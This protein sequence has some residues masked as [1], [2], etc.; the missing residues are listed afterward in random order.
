MSEKPDG[1]GSR[2]AAGQRAVLAKAQRAQ[3]KQLGDG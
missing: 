1:V 3:R 2:V